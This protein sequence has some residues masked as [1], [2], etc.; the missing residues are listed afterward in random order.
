MLDIMEI[1]H[2]HTHWVPITENPTHECFLFPMLLMTSPSESMVIWKQ[3]KVWI[4]CPRLGQK[5]WMVW[6]KPSTAHSSSPGTKGTSTFEREPWSLR[7]PG[8]WGTDANITPPT[9]KI[10]VTWG[11]VNLRN[12]HKEKIFTCSSKLSIKRIKKKERN[13]EEEKK[14]SAHFYLTTKPGEVGATQNSHQDQMVLIISIH[15]ALYFE[16]LEGWPCQVSS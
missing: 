14:P 9:M 8:V 1:N 2:T 13:S 10:L 15:L 4:K 11:P 6:G 7:N 5:G 3:F 12:K 16:D